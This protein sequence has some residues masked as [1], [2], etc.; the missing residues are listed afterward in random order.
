VRMQ[1]LEADRESMRQAI[2]SMGAE[3]AQVML[4]KEI[5]Q[6]LCKDAT[7]PVPAAAVAQHGFYK[8]GNTQPAM[9]ITVRPPRHPALLMQRKLVK[10]KPSLLAVVVKVISLHS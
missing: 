10:K 3:K 9:T 8:G 5:A 7:P 6:K 2:M 1:A 4:L